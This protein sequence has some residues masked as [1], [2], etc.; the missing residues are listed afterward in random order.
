MKVRD[1]IKAMETDGWVLDRTRLWE[2]AAYR[3]PC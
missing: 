2:N 3:H 1:V